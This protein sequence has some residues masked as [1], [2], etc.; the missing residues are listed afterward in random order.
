MRAVDRGRVTGNSD[1]TRL[2]KVCR[3]YIRNI[4]R[5]RHSTYSFL[6]LSVECGTLPTFLGLVSRVLFIFV[7][8]MEISLIF[9]RL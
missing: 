1:V 4:E 7:T 8:R 2:G 9:M 5:E 3:R 6:F